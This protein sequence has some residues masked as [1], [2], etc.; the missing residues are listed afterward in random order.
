L[1]ECIVR[2]HSTSLPASLEPWKGQNGNGVRR[3]QRLSF[4]AARTR[5]TAMTPRQHAWLLGPLAALLLPFLFWPAVVGL[6]GSFTDS[7]PAQ[8]AWRAVGFQNYAAVLGDEQVRFAFRNIVIMVL[9]AVPVE[10]GA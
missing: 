2:A 8:T 7:A 1:Q 4:Q 6:A 5:E 3:G 9:V 10:L